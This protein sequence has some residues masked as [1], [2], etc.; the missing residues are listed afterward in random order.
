MKTNS[1]RRNKTIVDLNNHNYR[2]NLLLRRNLVAEPDRVFQLDMFM[3][4]TPIRQ[5]DGSLLDVKALLAV[6]LA[7]GKAILGVNFVVKNKGN[8][9]SFLVFNQIKK[10]LVARARRVGHVLDL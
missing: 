4:P 7:S 8:V 10:L 5:P 6:D 1:H 2:P 3:L 9:K